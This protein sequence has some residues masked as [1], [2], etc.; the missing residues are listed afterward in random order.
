MTGRGYPY[1]EPR[2]FRSWIKDTK[3]MRFGIVDVV[4]AILAIMFLVLVIRQL[5][6]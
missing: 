3:R 1:G 5:I 6:Y 2:L 4:L